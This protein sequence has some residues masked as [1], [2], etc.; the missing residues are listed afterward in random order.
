MSVGII[1]PFNDAFQAAG[2]MQ[3]YKRIWRYWVQ[4][5]ALALA[6]ERPGHPTGLYDP[7]TRSAFKQHLAALD[8]TATAGTLAI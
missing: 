1:G 5:T 3:D 2:T 4:R 8:A 6:G 7:V